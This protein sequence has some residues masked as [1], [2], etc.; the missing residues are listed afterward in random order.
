MEAIHEERIRLDDDRTLALNV[1][2]PTEDD[3]MQT[4][5]SH[6]VTSCLRCNTAHQFLGTEEEARSAGYYTVKYCGKD[7][8]KASVILPVLREMNKT[9]ESIADDK[10]TAHRDTIFWL[11]RALN[12][13]SS[14]CEFSDQQMASSLMGTDSYHASHIFWSF[15]ANSFMNYQRE[16]WNEKGMLF[17]GP[18]VIDDNVHYILPEDGTIDDDDLDKGQTVF[19]TKTKEIRVAMQHEHYVRR[20][21]ALKDLSPYEWAAMIRV[22]KKPKGLQKVSTTRQRNATFPFDEDKS[23]WHKRHHQVLR[24]KFVIL[25]RGALQRSLGVR[26]MCIRLDPRCSYIPC[27][28]GH[29]NSPEVCSELMRTAVHDSMPVRPKYHPT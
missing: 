12:N 9:R 19:V 10:G 27:D 23:G 29:E 28:T 2:R 1:K 6:V 17:V 13:F 25:H 3:Q 20:G 24:S 16:N 14:L 8:V 22:E 7:P 26:W 5:A 4:E 15:H 18:D 21:R 11:T